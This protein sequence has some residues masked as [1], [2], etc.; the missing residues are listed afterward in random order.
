MVPSLMDIQS[1]GKD[2][3]G[4]AMCY[5]STNAPWCPSPN[6]FQQNEEEH[7]KN[8]GNPPGIADINLTAQPN[9]LS[10]PLLTMISSQWV[11]QFVEVSTSYVAQMDLR[12]RFST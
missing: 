5:P 8:T 10:S 2:Q 9:I 3:Q 11:L 12:S 4:I 1:K 6:L 7:V